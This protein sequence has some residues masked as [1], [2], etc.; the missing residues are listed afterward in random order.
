MTTSARVPPIRI[1]TCNA[2]PVNS[3][4]D[5]VL[6]WMIAFRR[7][8]WNFSLQRAVEWAVQLRKPLVIFEPLRV[9][10]RWASDRLHRFVIDGMADNARRLQGREPQGILY[11][12]YVEPRSD[13]ASGLLEALSRHAS[14]VVTDDF[15]SFFLPR[16]VARVGRMLPVKLEQVDSNGLLPLRATDRVFTTAFSFRSYLQKGLPEHLGELPQEDPLARVRLPPIEKLP[17]GI[18]RRWPTAS[19]RLLAGMK[20]ELAALPIDHSVPVAEIRGGAGAANQRWNEFLN[21]R[22]ADYA[23]LANQPDAEGRSGLSPYLHFGHISPHQL[24]HDLMTLEEWTP[25]RLSRRTGG[26]R[27]GWWGVSPGAESWLDQVVTWRELGYNMTSHRT[28]YD[29][30]ESL[31]DWS[32]ATLE[33]HAR[34]R[35]EYVYSLEQFAASA[36]HD[37][38]WNAA[39]TQLRRE[40]G[41]HNYLRML[42]GKK[43]LEWTA[44]P[45]EAL[46]IL[47][48]LNNRYALDGRNPNSYSGI[49]WTL[50]RY[51]RAWGPERPIFGTVRY[52]SS[53]NTRR[54]LP[55][56]QYLETYGSGGTR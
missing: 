28:D 8:G 34:D 19:A 55:V 43:I 18:A 26:Q 51:D 29:R 12:P 15:P 45:R 36:T 5:Y 42:W 17:L 52:M 21:R 48:E 40:G 2:A 30:Y 23:E 35:R 1:T 4:G 39:Q 44:S 46:A 20:K 50:G 49:F 22:L 37:D 7:T 41:M 33:K 3:A 53:Q 13:A 14:V 38:L 25:E 16:M 10:Y 47:I 56:K 32:R 24:F 9:Q 11:Y 6:Y 27:A 54:K 31:P